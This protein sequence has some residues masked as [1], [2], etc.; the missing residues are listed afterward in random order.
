M[1]TQGGLG[2]ISDAELTSM[3]DQLDEIHHDQAMPAM[4]TAVDQWCE[5]ISEERASTERLDRRRTGRRTFLL[6]AAGATAGGVLLAACGSSAKKAS[7][8]QLSSAMAS[9]LS[10][11]AMAA[12]LENLGVYAYKAGVKAA[13]AGKLG[14]VPAAVPVFALVAMGQHIDHANAWN[15]ALTAAGEPAVTFTDPALTPTVNTAFGQVTDVAGLLGLALLVENIA[16]QTYQNGVGVLSAPTAIGVAATIHPVEMQHAAI[17]YFAL[18]Q[19]PGIQG[20]E[21]NKYAS[22]APLAFNPTALARPP[23]DVSNK[24]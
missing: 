1:S 3:V 11:A 4:R 13:T 10:V 8:P 21:A 17:L 15:A 23:S 16:A 20:T 14:K 18:G 9:D 5:V 7:R 24:L 6:G 2:Q 22:G 12:S 19:Y